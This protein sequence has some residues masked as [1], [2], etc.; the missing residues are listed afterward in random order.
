M[1]GK[2]EAHAAAGHAAEHPEAPEIFAEGFAGAGDELLGVAVAHPR[3]H[4]LE[5]AEEVFGEGA[6]EAADVA[7]GKERENVVEGGDGAAAGG[8]LR[9]AAEEIFL[10]G[11]L[12]DGADVL[13]HAA[14]DEHEGIG[15]FLPSLG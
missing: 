5:R 14:V 1:R 11:H 8:E 9:F 15:E 12:E 2:N 3:D 4:R 13:G 10:G 6:A 7:R